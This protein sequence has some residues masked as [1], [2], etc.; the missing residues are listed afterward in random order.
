M[1]LPDPS[2]KDFEVPDLTVPK[3]MTLTKLESRRALLDVVDRRYRE[4]ITH[5]EHA[6]LDT[7]RQ[8]AWNM[9][10]SESVRNAFDL[11]KEPEKTRDA[12]GRYPFGQSVLLARRLV[13]AGSRFVTA[14]GYKRQ[15]WDTHSS[16][17][18]SMKEDLAPTLDQTFSTLLDD[19]TQR[20]LL[21]ST[22]VI[23]MGEFGRTYDLNS[24]GGRDHWGE[25]WSILVGGGGIRGG[26][27]VGSSDDKGAYPVDSRVTMGDFF[28]TVYK[29]FG[30]DWHKEYMH[31]VGRPLKIANSLNDETGT[32]VQQLV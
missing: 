17:N 4:K 15:A 21:E 3:N 23:A 7:F 13:E 5:V 16:N 10:L 29:A 6:N 27:V 8:Q 11:S 22:V 30:I 26:E 14:N 20:G 2:S 19:L 1:V 25:C 32:P 31:P 12:Y 9:I 18:K 28:A 24:A